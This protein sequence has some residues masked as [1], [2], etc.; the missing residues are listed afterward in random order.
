MIWIQ[1]VIARCLSLYWLG[2]TQLLYRW[3]LGSLG[4]R[5]R[6][7]HPL[8]LRNPENIFIGNNVTVHS[9]GWLFT[10][11]MAQKPAPK[12]IIG[13]GTDIG[14]FNHITCVN[15]VEIGRKVLIADRVH[16]SDNSHG[17]ENPA[18]PIIDQ[19]VISKGP[20]IIGDGTWLGEN[21][22]VLSCRIG[23]N[24]VIGSNAVVNRDIPDY[25]VAV[26]I[27]ARVVKRFNSDS[28]EWE[29]CD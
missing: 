16:I 7:V 9:L 13:D 24:C 18:L 8:K 10:L 17:F 29:R 2:K 6:I 14:H 1:K 23:R 22:S 28:G 3:C 15:R 4:K 5:S 12:L 19:P 25:S 21:V 20:V 11:P 27:P 26:G